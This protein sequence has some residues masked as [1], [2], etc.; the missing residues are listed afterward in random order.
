VKSI[1]NELLSGICELMHV[2]MHMLG[3][4]AKRSKATNLDNGSLIP[5]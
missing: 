3:I 4:F 1:G 2:C 5:S